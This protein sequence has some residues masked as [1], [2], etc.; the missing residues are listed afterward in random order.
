LSTNEEL[1]ALRTAASRGDIQAMTT[2]GKRLIAA[3]KSSKCVQDG[4]TFLK[5]AMEAGNGEAAEF[6]AI[7]FA[8]GVRG[9]QDWNQALDYLALSASLEWQPAS[10]QLSILANS[11]N[12]NGVWDARKADIRELRAR[13][14][15]ESL[16]QIP[17][18]QSLCEAPR[19]RKFD[20]FLPERF[21]DWMIDLARPKLA[22]ARTY[23]ETAAEGKESDARTNSSVSFSLLDLD[24]VLLLIQTRIS[25]IAIVPMYT[26]E[27]SMVMHYKIGEQFHPHYDYLD[28]TKAAHAADM[29]KFGQ[30]LA[31]CLIYLNQDF[32][33]AETS[34]P[35]IGQKFRCDKGGALLFANVDLNG[36]PDPQT[37]HA[38]LPPIRGEKWLFSQW[39]RSG[40][41]PQ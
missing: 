29:R 7:M 3:P 36:Q 40:P 38:G 16:M 33:G 31:T 2:V 25:K 8:S 28:P 4:Q 24:L 34:F 19:I 20:N 30:R 11:P 27:N 23:D 13:I 1:G 14:N 5:Q 12:E 35:K 32:E 21:C 41:L 17:E 39:I 15:V 18:K 26:M 22:R 6:V 37:L 9:E 10:W